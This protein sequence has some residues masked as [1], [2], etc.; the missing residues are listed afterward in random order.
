MSGPFIKTKSFNIA[1]ICK[2]EYD[3]S[4]NPI[5]IGKASSNTATSQAKWQIQKLTY[6]GSSNLT[7]TQWADGTDD[8][9]KIW[10]SR[11]SYTYA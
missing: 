9:T 7:D 4:N 3:A 5:Y 11:I 6:D 2:Y 8:F 10:D 1:T